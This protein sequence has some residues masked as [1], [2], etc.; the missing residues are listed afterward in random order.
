MFVYTSWNS[1]FYSRLLALLDL[2]GLQRSFLKITYSWTSECLFLVT[3]TSFQ[4]YGWV[5]SMMHASSCFGGYLNLIWP[6]LGALIH[7]YKLLKLLQEEHNHCM[8]LLVSP[9]YL[10]ALTRERARYAKIFRKESVVNS[11]TAIGKA[12]LDNTFTVVSGDTYILFSLSNSCI[13]L[14]DFITLPMNYIICLAQCL[15]AVG[16]I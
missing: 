14:F 16:L 15:L 1:Q 9:S 2:P 6:I 12:N 7:A 8:Q 11:T 3:L 5:V 4:F 10:K 13:S